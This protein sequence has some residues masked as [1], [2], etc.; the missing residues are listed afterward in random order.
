MC[1]EFSLQTHTS[2]S[3]EDSFLEN[4]GQGEKSNFCHVS[5]HFS[6][7]SQELQNLLDRVL[8]DLDSEVIKS[9]CAFSGSSAI[10]ALLL[11][12]R[13]VISAV[14]QSLGRSLMTLKYWLKYVEIIYFQ[15]L[16]S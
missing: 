9:P 5:H 16:S 8:T 4:R 7:I 6:P 13:L 14:G 1:E 15:D 11:G 2:L 3:Q 12:D 10:L